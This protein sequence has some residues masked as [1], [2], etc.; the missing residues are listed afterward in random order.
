MAGKIIVDMD[1][2]LFGDF[3]KMLESRNETTA[4]VIKNLVKSW[5]VEVEGEPKPTH[6][7]RAAVES[8]RLAKKAT[9]RRSN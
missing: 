8:K 9:S 6:F 1:E 2:R 7:R 5:L 4:F 3:R